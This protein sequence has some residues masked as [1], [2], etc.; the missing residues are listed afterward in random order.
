M[1]NKLLDMIKFE[2]NQFIMLVIIVFLLSISLSTAIGNLNVN[3]KINSITRKIELIRSNFS[4]FTLFYSN[5]NLPS[6]EVI[7]MVHVL[8][9]LNKN[10]HELE[11]I[12]EGI[13][14]R[15]RILVKSLTELYKQKSEALLTISQN[16]YDT[17]VEFKNNNDKP[18]IVQSLVSIEKLKLKYM[19]NTTNN[20]FIKNSI[21]NLNDIYYDL[22]SHVFNQKAN[23]ELNK[24]LKYFSTSHIKTSNSLDRTIADK[25][26]QILNNN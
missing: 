16:Y 1:K 4:S 20:E 13:N 8:Q 10:S 25:E 7:A 2:T 19:D 17:Y 11:T 6:Q 12:S 14:T 23:S 15:Q 22:G 21:D 5:M 26:Y 9:E 18:K 3:N 24:Y